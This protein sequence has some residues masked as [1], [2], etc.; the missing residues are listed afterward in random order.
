VSPALAIVAGIAV[1]LVNDV[2]ATFLR[3]NSPIATLAMSLAG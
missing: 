1:G 3:I 2:I